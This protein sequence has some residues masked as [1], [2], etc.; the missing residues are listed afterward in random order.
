MVHRLPS[1]GLARCDPCPPSPRPVPCRSA[2]R[3]PLCLVRRKHPSRWA[4]LHQAPRTVS[5]PTA[6]R[7]P[8]HSWPEVVSVLGAGASP[9]AWNTPVRWRGSEIPWGGRNGVVTRW[10]GGGGSRTRKSRRAT[11]A[12]PAVLAAQL[13]RGVEGDAQRPL[14]HRVMARSFCTNGSY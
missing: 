12:P 14:Y 10:R 2:R 6:R 9:E 11:A 13:I 8:A 3:A 4:R 1:S 7:V 5:S